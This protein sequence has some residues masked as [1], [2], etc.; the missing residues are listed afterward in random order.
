MQAWG[1]SWEQTPQD[2]DG[3]GRGGRRCSGPSPG[4]SPGK[5]GESCRVPLGEEAR[6][7]GGV[8]SQHSLGRVALHADE[9]RLHKADLA[10]GHVLAQ[11][12]GQAGHLGPEDLD[13]VTTLEGHL[14]GPGALVVCHRRGQANGYGRKSIWSVLGAGAEVGRRRPQPGTR[15]PAVEPSNACLGWQCS[16]ATTHEGL[17]IYVVLRGVTLSPR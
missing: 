15:S 8:G 9:T 1:H 12:P 10:R 11:E 5:Q 3:V 14:F 2:R 16:S 13:E 6:A 4:L 17:D 7:Q